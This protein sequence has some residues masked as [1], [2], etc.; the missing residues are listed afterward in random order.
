MKILLLSIEIDRKDSIIRELLEIVEGDESRRTIEELN[1][2]ITKF[3]SETRELHQI[4]AMLKENIS[5][6]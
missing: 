3:E 2:R 4:N 1:I 6:I 5:S